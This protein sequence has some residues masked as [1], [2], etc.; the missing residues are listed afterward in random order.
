M[1]FDAPIKIMTKYLPRGKPRLA[2]ARIFGISVVDLE[3][4]L[5]Q[6]HVVTF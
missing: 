2:L 5:Q 6:I 1:V 4:N 3:V